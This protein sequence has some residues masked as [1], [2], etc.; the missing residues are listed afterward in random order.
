MEKHTQQE[1]NYRLS[2]WLIWNASIE[3]LLTPD[4]VENVFRELLS[5]YDPPTRCVERVQSMSVRRPG[6]CPSSSERSVACVGRTT[7][8]KPG[9]ASIT[10]GHAMNAVSPV[11]FIRASLQRRFFHMSAPK[12]TYNA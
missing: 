3:Q 12:S 4:E 5:Y 8:R 1:V 11:I 9:T 6:P 10:S 7:E 2:K